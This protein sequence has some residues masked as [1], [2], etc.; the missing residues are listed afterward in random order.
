[1]IA[2]ARPRPAPC[3]RTGIRR[4]HRPTG[5]HT[6]PT[7]DDGFT[8]P[9]PS[10][11][12]PLTA[13]LSGRAILVTGAT[14]GLGRPLALACASR[15]A[16]VVAPRPNRAQA[17]GAVRRNRRRRAPAADDPSARPRHRR[18]RGLRQRRGGDSRAVR[19]PGRHRPRGRG[20]GFAGPGRAPGLRRLAQGAPGQRHCRHGA[21]ARHRAAARRGARCGGRLH[22]RHARAGAARVLGSIRGSQGGPRRV[23]DDAG[24]RMGKP[25]EPARQCG[26][27]GTDQLAAA[28]ADAS[29]RAARGAGRSGRACRPLSAGCSARSRRARAA[30]SSTLRR[31]SRA[32]RPRRRW[33]RTTPSTARP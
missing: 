33:W 31:G 11:N 32:R 20:P 25:P 18:A 28:R 23:R 7:P 21:H 24:R 27:A 19:P 26:R 30:S 3:R 16:T 1:M 15:G 12:S 4:I 5:Q 22:A 6:A 10:P 29:R 8:M 9:L 13:D 14:G 17:G 2:A